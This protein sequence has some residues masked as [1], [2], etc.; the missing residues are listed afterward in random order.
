M[1]S[2]IETDRLILRSWD[3]GDATAVLEMYAA[4][5]SAQAGDASHVVGLDSDAMRSRISRWRS[6]DG[7]DRGC[8]GHWAIVTRHDGRLIGGISLRFV[9]ADDGDLTLEWGLGRSGRGHG[10]LTEA[11]RAL[12]RWA[13]H[14]RGATEVFA[15]VPAADPGAIAATQEMGMDWVEE[16]GRDRDYEV[17]RARHGSLA[18]D[19]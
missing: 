9:P 16:L 1:T 3:L 19:D 11:G 4:W 12:I 15:V 8:T 18:L 5:A 7:S 13:V 10:Y 14:E 17:Y 6:A 2:T